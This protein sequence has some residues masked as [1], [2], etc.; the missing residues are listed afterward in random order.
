MSFV[1][2]TL[3]GWRPRFTV[4]HDIPP[5]AKGTWVLALFR[6]PARR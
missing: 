1:V 2:V 4:V 3:D 5:L 6:F